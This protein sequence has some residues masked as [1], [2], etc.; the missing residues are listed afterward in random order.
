MTNSIFNEQVPAVS[1]QEK[2]IIN[3]QYFNAD[4]SQKTIMQKS[5]AWNK[6]MD[7]QT[8]SKIK[9]STT[10][11]NNYRPAKAGRATASQHSMVNASIYNDEYTNAVP[12]HNYSLNVK[13]ANSSSASLQEDKELSVGASG[14]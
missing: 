1:N 6:P 7:Y 9:R 10:A 5:N 12:Q 14:N 11:Y 13:L 2:D 4:V 3:N 8:Q